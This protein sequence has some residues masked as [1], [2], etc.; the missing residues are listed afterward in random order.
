[1]RHPSVSLS[2]LIA[3]LIPAAVA[4]IAAP[5]PRLA[6]SPDHRFLVSAGGRPFF[7]LADTAWELF[8]RLDRKQAVEYLDLR[9]A[10]KFN[11]IQAVALAE[12][13][14]VTDPNAYGDLPLVDKTPPG[15]P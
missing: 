7:Y 10:Q 4:A 8:H 11:A 5:L 14:G 6:V 12:L 2:G 13:D 15:P 1:M 9:A 3:F